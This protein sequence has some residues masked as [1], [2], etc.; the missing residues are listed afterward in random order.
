MSRWPFSIQCEIPWHFPDTPVHVKC[1]SYHVGT[2]V[3]VSGGGK[4]TTVHDLKPKWNA[5]AQQSQ[6]WMQIYTANN[7]QF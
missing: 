1:Y 5:P 7:K 4:N 3:T 6:E 2:S